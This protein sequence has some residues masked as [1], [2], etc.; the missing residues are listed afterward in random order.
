MF[1]LHRLPLRLHRPA[2]RL[3]LGLAAGLVA[4]AAAGA[5]AQ[6]LT[7]SAAASL[8][9]A[10][11]EIGSA[12]QTAHPGTV[13]RFNFGASGALLAQIAQGAPVDVFASADTETMDRALARQLVDP[14][15]RL[16]FARNE[17]VLV[18]PRREPATL[19]GLAD[20]AGANTKRIAIGS[21]ATVPAGHYAQAALERAGLWAAVRPKLVYAENVRQSLNY[22]SRGEVDAAFVYRT[23]ALLDAAT[24]RVDASVETASPVRYPIARVAASRQAD[25]ARR[26]IAFV[27]GEPGQAVLARHGF[28]RP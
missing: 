28:G 20:L 9:N 11:R 25:A 3:A 18:S 17:L 12:Y 8:Q 23:D 27:A 6:A 15:S 7:V 24:V 13:L 4:L 16:D 1:C 2:R 22:V 21:P 10:M 5:S 14:A 26:F 19:R